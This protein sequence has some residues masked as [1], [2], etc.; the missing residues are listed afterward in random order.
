MTPLEKLTA[1]LAEFGVGYRIEEGENNISLCLEA[2]EHD[3]VVGYT[4]FVSEFAF[5]KDGAFIEVSIME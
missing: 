3:K 1:L 5:T 4:G 2:K